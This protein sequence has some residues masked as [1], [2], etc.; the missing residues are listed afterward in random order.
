MFGGEPKK[1]SELL[2]MV[3]ADIIVCPEVK[4]DIRQL[5]VCLIT[6]IFSCGKCLN[7]FCVGYEDYLSPTTFM[8]DC[9]YDKTIDEL[10]LILA[11]LSAKLKLQAMSAIEWRGI[12]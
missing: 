4:Q 3:M 5:K 7:G 10:E 2:E 9:L 8:F 11:E 1:F 6:D 12:R